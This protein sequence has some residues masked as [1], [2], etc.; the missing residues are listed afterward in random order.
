MDIERDNYAL[1]DAWRHWFERCAVKLCTADEQRR[2][3]RQ[4]E[5]AFWREVSRHDGVSAGDYEREDICD[6]FDQYFFLHGDVDNPKALKAYFRDRIDPG[7][8]DGMKKL[9]CGT[10][11]SSRCGRIKDIVRESI[12]L[13]KGWRPRW[14]NTHDGKKLIWERPYEPLSEDD[15]RTIEPVCYPT[16]YAYLDRDCRIWQRRARQLLDFLCGNGEINASEVPILVYAIVNG[17]S[18][19]NATLQRSLGVRQVQCYKKVNRMKEEMR[20]YMQNNDIVSTDTLIVFALRNEVAR[21]IDVSILD[22]LAS[23]VGEEWR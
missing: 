22:S 11:F 9:I 16:A 4:I 10:F 17:V 8:S 18:P 23:E 12:S 13:V 1:D 3:R 21:R 7:V 20:R 19:S 14:M 6:L 5:S 2:L 15:S